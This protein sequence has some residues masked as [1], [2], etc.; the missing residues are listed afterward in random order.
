MDQTVVVDEDYRSRQLENRLNAV[1]RHCRIGKV[2]SKKK[3]VAQPI[4]PISYKEIFSPLPVV[5]QP[6]ENPQLYGMSP[7]KCSCKLG[8]ACGNAA[9]PYALIATC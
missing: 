8:Q 5:P 3:L 4:G 6:W 2:S 7:R 1:V 9:C